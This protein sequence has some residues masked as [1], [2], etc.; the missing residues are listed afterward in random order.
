MGC[1][2]NGKGKQPVDVMK[3]EELLVQTLLFRYIIIYHHHVFQ[4]LEDV[5][6]EIRM[7]KESKNEKLLTIL[8]CAGISKK[9]FIVAIEEFIKF[10]QKQRDKMY[11]VN[12]SVRSPVNMTV[13]KTTSSEFSL[14]IDVSEESRTMSIYGEKSN[15]QKALG[16]LTAKFGQ[17]NDVPS[18]PV[19]TTTNM[20]P[21]RRFS[22][23]LS[24]NVNVMVYQGDLVEEKVDVIVN[25]ANERLEHCGGAAEAIAKAGGKSIQS[26][27]NE[28]MRKRRKALAAGEVE[29]TAGGQLP[30]KFIVHAV[31]PRRIEH[32]K[33]SAEKSLLTAVMNS[34]KIASTNDA[35][36][37][38]IPAISSGVFGIPV[39]FCARVLFDAVEAFAKD[40]RNVKGLHEVRF[41][42]IDKP[43]TDV[44]VQEMRK[45]YSSNVR[46]ETCLG[47]SPPSAGKPSNGTTRND[48]ERQ[49]AVLNPL[50]SK[51]A[52]L[53]SG[54]FLQSY[55]VI[56][57][58]MSGI[59]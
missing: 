25:P 52:A 49:M 47:N 9:T 43:T 48:A 46:K 37:I 45:R 23:T 50:M 27:S 7:K 42:N 16:H 4:A 2:Q 29:I 3:P 59:L 36:S 51:A 12:Q 55:Y 1:K 20:L 33:E 18:K 44:F 21:S 56:I 58:F 54:K 17:L 15:V 6:G 39:D 13:I 5:S 32:S 30:C 10:W 28:I 34:L 19:T 35:R 22:C 41:V 57:L 14:V 38:S 26:E 8:P 24:N 53:G 40:K 31:G 11:T